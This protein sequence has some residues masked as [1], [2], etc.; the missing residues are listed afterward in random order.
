MINSSSSIN[1]TNVAEASSLTPKKVIA[2]KNKKKRNKASIIEKQPEINSYTD[3]RTRKAVII[4][5]SDIS[6]KE[7]LT[8]TT[9]KSRAFENE[10]QINSKFRYSFPS[11]TSNH[12]TIS[13]ELDKIY[14]RMSQLFTKVESSIN[15]KQTLLE[16]DKNTIKEFIVE[17]INIKQEIITIWNKYH[18]GI[19]YKYVGNARA[20]NMKLED[21]L[22]DI[23]QVQLYNCYSEIDDNTNKLIIINQIINQKSIVCVDLCGSMF[24]ANITDHEKIDNLN[25]KEILI[26]YK[27]LESFYK[28][29]VS[30]NTST[31]NNQI[32]VIVSTMKLCLDKAHIDYCK[33]VNDSKITIKFLA[34]VMKFAGF[35]DG[36][37]NYKDHMK[38]L[39]LGLDLYYNNIDNPLLK[40][41]HDT[42]LTD[43]A[44]IFINEFS[45]LNE[46]LLQAT[47]NYKQ[48]EKK[49]S[50]DQKKLD[51]HKQIYSQ[52]LDSIKQQIKQL[53]IKYNIDVTD[54]SSWY[55]TFME[56]RFIDVFINT[57]TVGCSINLAKWVDLSIKLKDIPQEHIE[58]KNEIKQ[59]LN[60]LEKDY[61]SLINDTREWNNIPTIILSLFCKCLIG[62]SLEFA[63]GSCTTFKNKCLAI[64][65]AKINQTFFPFLGTTLLAIANNDDYD[66]LLTILNMLDF[67]SQQP[68]DKSKYTTSSKYLTA[69]IITYLLDKNDKLKL[70]QKYFLFDKA[71]KLYL[72]LADLGTNKAY[73][74]LAE[75]TA[76]LAKVKMHN[77]NFLEAASLYDEASEY[78]RIL[79][80]IDNLDA[81]LQD[82]A[83]I[84]INCFSA[85][86]EMLRVLDK[87][88]ETLLLELTTETPKITTK[89]KK[90]SHKKTAGT[91]KN[92]GQQEIA[93]DVTIKEVANWQKT[94][95]TTDSQHQSKKTTKATQKTII[96]LP[97]KDEITSK[98]DF[99]KIIQE[100][101][102]YPT[103]L[104]DS[105]ALLVKILQN[106]YFN[107]LETKF[108]NGITNADSWIVLLVYQHMAYYHFLQ[109]KY[110]KEIGHNM[111]LFYTTD[112]SKKEKV[113]F[114]N[115]SSEAEQIIRKVIKL[116][117]CDIPDV[118][119]KDLREL[120]LSLSPDNYKKSP[121]KNRLAATVSTYGHLIS[122]D[123]ISQGRR[124]KNR[125]A[126]KIY[127]KADEINPKRIIKKLA[128]KA[129]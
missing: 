119:T 11:K 101:Q 62:K 6:M 89:S 88:R 95:K 87:E 43:N 34:L 73:L 118:E 114:A 93:A 25:F 1:S 98:R 53:F 59:W 67:I 77:D 54:I 47:D 69:Q 71:K 126:A 51:M 8:R 124:G 29:G 99:W 14:T 91:T 128:K 78:C 92:I 33:L 82:L 21:K 120:V 26:K 46:D 81:E 60:I 15:A 24:L 109:Q 12:Y 23:I 65:H 13:P 66:E 68:K 127:D 100:L 45:K 35:Y 3:L 40:G 108:K 19:P 105:Y 18:P 103:N 38:T 106:D 76:S 61:K 125:L 85:E 37:E 48:G 75:T 42:L 27:K 32:A 80:E 20:S 104:E 64:L 74:L 102:M 83:I 113:D 36:S 117:C 129:S 49:L 63:F 86:A 111:E 2:K 107:I 122:L 97:T 4:N 28:K 52:E 39:S 112:A 5:G 96:K 17:L 115:T 50:Q 121:F 79:S 16:E 31:E 7:F 30:S 123:D 70:D 84:N 41:I 90:K 57:S 55:D 56:E 110:A 94:Y 10:D 58:I 72:E 22:L 9:I 116:V 44:I